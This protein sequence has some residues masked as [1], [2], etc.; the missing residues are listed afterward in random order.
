MCAKY[1]GAHVQLRIKYKYEGIKTAGVADYTSQ[2]PTKHFR[3]IRYLCPT[4]MSNRP[5]NK[6]MFIK[7]AQN[8]RMYEYSS[9][10][11]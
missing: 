8:R 11:V 7:C 1:M 2:T 9:C 6:K 10:K 5:K 3:W 4:D